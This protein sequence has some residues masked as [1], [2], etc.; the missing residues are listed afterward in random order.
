MQ[1]AGPVTDA[2]SVHLYDTMNSNP[3]VNPM[4]PKAWAGRRIGMNIRAVLD[5][6]E[7]SSRALSSGNPSQPSSVIEV[8]EYGTSFKDWKTTRNFGPTGET[9]WGVLIGV[10]GK[11]LD[12]IQ[13]DSVIIKAIPFLVH[14]YAWFHGGDV[15]STGPFSLYKPPE[16]SQPS[17]LMMFYEM[18]RDIDGEKSVVQLTAASSNSNGGDDVG[19]VL[20][21]PVQAVLVRGPADATAG[22]ATAWLLLNNLNA[23]EAN[24]SVQ[25]PA[26]LDFNVSEVKTLMWDETLAAPTIRTFTG[27]AAALA[28]TMKLPPN[29]FTVIQL[30]VAVPS[31]TRTNNTT[32]FRVFARTLTAANGTTAPAGTIFPVVARSSTMA[33]ASI[34]G[35]SANVTGNFLI[36]VEAAVG[37]VANAVVLRLCGSSWLPFRSWNVP[38]TIDVAA[39]ATSGAFLEGARSPSTQ[40]R[41][42]TVSGYDAPDADGVHF[43]CF[44]Y[45]S[46][47]WTIPAA[48]AATIV[49]NQQ[50]TEF[51][52]ST[53]AVELDVLS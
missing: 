17:E 45:R 26:N 40:L 2:L 3:G 18:W 49:A 52:V 9:N 6:I 5:L 43:G 35:A 47:N 41:S 20:D 44:E 36:G 22:T 39:T 50:P 8:S 13:R 16:Y 32:R 38:P 51:T 15:N 7:S 19:Q 28:G 21:L 42:A 10:N 24:V 23:W 27:G 4:D 53:M 29:A 12:L 30:S 46:A 37:K 14:D 1:Q 25:L 31:T 33:L 11:I 48:F 34:V